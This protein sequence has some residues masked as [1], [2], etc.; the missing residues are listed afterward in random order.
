MPD[1]AVAVEEAFRESYGLVVATVARKTG[2]IDLAEEAIQDAFAEALRSWPVTGV[3]SNPPGWI[4][5]VAHRRAIDRIRRQ[6]NLAR[7]AAILAGMEKSAEVEPDLP[8]DPEPIP[9]DRL[10]MI[11]ACCHP[12]LSA[13]KQVALTL[14]TLGG[15]T[16]PEIAS[17]F[18]VAEPTMAQRLVR[19]KAKI[20]DAGIP[21]EVPGP[22]E[23][24]ERLGAVLSVIYLIF[25]EG[26]F[27]SSGDDLVRD[28]LADSAI[29]LGRLISELM[30][31]EAEARGLLALMLL[32]HSRR[33]ARTGD[34]GELVLL[35][36]QDR[37]RWDRP[38]I[39]EAWS[40]LRR[41]EA[42]PGAG[43][44]VLQARIAAAHARA[45]SWE[46][47]DWE[48]I[49]GIYDRLAVVLPS[50]VVRLNKAVSVGFARGPE[51]GLD[52]LELLGEE[53][54]GHHRYHTARAELLSRLGKSTEARAE[55]D[56]ALRSNLNTTERRHLEARRESV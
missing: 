12:S 43:P 20:R 23:M 8:G 52:E 40:Q 46:E 24:P 5:T 37:S 55:I 14:R 18:L 17:A 35:E 53:L 22:G 30:P 7:K 33:E 13:D 19:A 11:F 1:P 32:Q 4:S 10:Q 9:D 38:M 48:E 49:V 36:D 39:E 28:D 2:D 31:D 25:N 26:Y 42:G 27:S 16:T 34:E 50:P 44:Y 21:F 56:I 29:E 45:P 3:P 47:T 6:Q 54:S 51:A 15:L 41:A